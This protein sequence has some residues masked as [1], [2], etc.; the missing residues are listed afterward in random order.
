MVT[1]IFLV[2]TLGPWGGGERGAKFTVTA[3]QGS[4]KFTVS[5]RKLEK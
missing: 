2:S 1:L 5:H 4:G 3:G